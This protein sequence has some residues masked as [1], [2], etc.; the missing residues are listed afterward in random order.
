MKKNYYI[1][2]F[3]FILAVFFW[4]LPMKF[5]FINR[6]NISGDPAFYL[7][8]LKW[9]P[10][11]IS[12]GLNPFLTKAFWAPFGQNLVWTTSCSSIAILM[13]PITNLFGP[14]FSYNLTTVISLTLAPY[15]IYLINRKIGLKQTSSIFGGLVFFFS[16]YVWGQLLGHLNLDIIF[17]VVFIVYLYVLRFKGSISRTKYYILLGI[18]LAIQFGI[19]N[20]IYA[21]FIV[22]SFIGFIILILLYLKD[23]YYKQKIITFGF[24]TLIGISISVFL[25]IPYIYYIFYGYVSQNLNDNSFYVADPINYFIPTPITLVFGNVFLPISSKFAGNFSE[26]GAYLGLPLIFISISFIYLT[27]KYLNKQSRFYVFLTLFFIIAIILSFGPYLRILGHH[28]I[29]MPWIVFS[30][31]PLI[32]QA[33]PTR[34]TLYVDLTVSIIAALWFEKFSKKSVKYILSGL[35][36]LFLIPNL[37]LYKG[38]LIRDYIPNFI[39]TNEYKNYIKKGSNVIILPAY[40]DAGFQGPLWQYTTNFYFNLSQMLAGPIPK[41]INW[42]L[43]SFFASSGL[44]NESNIYDFAAYL[45][46]CNVKYIIISENNKKL[47]R[48]LDKLIPLTSKIILS[49]VVLYKVDGKVIKDLKEKGYEYNLKIYST[50]LN[51]SQNFLSSGQSLS[52]LY[53]QYLESHGYLD[54]SFGY[55]TGAAKNWTQDGGWIGQWDCPDGKGKCFGIGLVGDINILKPIID[56]YKPQALRIFFPYPKIYNQNTK[57]TNGQLLMIFR[58]SGQ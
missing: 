16:S 22:F 36:I 41:Q 11:A 26:E 15:G 42:A 48:N 58:A 3:Y 8:A 44:S 51:S 29:P 4:G 1:L 53:P 39:K 37:Y 10:Y 43:V 28:T 46:K 52:N 9:W 56:K 23:E 49:D 2:M 57:E 32:K 13:W 21:S 24:D 14:I 30:H 20:E 6:L 27:I 31:L 45:K 12:H 33:L 54:K 5:D 55:Q 18:L 34:F 7:W 47:E 40:Q 35:A 17:I 50:L 19:S 38:S 25:L